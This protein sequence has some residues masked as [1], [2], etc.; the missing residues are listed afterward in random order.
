MYFK[1]FYISLKCYNKAYS[2]T[3]FNSGCETLADIVCVL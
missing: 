3:F 2:F 1:I